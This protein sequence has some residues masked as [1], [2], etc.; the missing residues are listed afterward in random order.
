[1]MDWETS[2]TTNNTIQIK[3]KFKTNYTFNN[4]LH[5]K[6]VL[7][8]R[9][10]KVFLCNFE[11]RFFYTLVKNIYSDI[12]HANGLIRL[13]VNL[14]H[15]FI[16][17]FKSKKKLSQVSSVAVTLNHT[18]FHKYLEF[19]QKFQKTVQ[20]KTEVTG[21]NLKLIGISLVDYYKLD[22]S[23][24]TIVSE[25]LNKKIKYDGFSAFYSTIGGAASS[26]GEELYFQV[27][28]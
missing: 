3:R 5:F 11:C 10:L 2:T 18:L 14:V 1:M 7:E 20:P 22:R 25:W 24:F 16:S 27:S 15:Y 13:L 28:W 12:E 23:G 9:I 17:S 21:W 26:L 4:C 19:V 6:V 8:Q